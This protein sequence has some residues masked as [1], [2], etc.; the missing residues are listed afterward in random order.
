[1][2]REDLDAF[3]PPQPFDSWI[4]NESIYSYEAPVPYPEDGE[5]YTWNEET[6]S[7]EA[8]PAE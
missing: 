6:T 8:I 5:P 2:Y 1:L 3:I 4:L 7:W